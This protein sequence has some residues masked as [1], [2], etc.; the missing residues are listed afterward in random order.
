MEVDIFSVL[1]ADEGRLAASRKGFTL[2]EILI[3]VAI[4]GILSAIAIPQFSS[5]RKSAYCAMI[6]SDLVNLAITQEAYYYNYDLYLAVT[7]GS[8]GS[9]NVPNF[10]WSAGVTLTSSTGSVSNW[11]AVAGHPN[12]DTGPYTYDST[13]GGLQ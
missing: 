11:S 9:S 5:Y 4:I 2:V 8:G 12:C 6:K 7:Q 3:V 1:R 13:A 10:N